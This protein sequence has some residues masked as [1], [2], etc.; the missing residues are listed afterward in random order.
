MQSRHASV[1]LSAKEKLVK[2]RLNG[3]LFWPKFGIIP[4]VITLIYHA[5]KD[6]NWVN[7]LFA[8]NLFMY[9]F[10]YN[11]LYNLVENMKAFIKSL[12]F[13]FILFY[14]TRHDTE[15]QLL[16]FWLFS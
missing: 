11:L 1:V 14:I 16:M 7:S 13:T 10:L 6:F 3:L 2:T 15:K 4:L 9:I 8:I 12:C 5:A